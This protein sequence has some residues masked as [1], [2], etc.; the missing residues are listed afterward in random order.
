MN[1]A[2][3]SI[4]S[5]TPIP[6]GT[7]NVVFKSDEDSGWEVCPVIGWATVVTSATADGAA[8]TDVQPAFLWG[9]MVWTESDL[10]EHAADFTGFG[11]RRPFDNLGDTAPSSKPAIVRRKGD[12]A[13]VTTL[14]RKPV[15]K[16]SEE[17]HS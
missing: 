5:I 15:G 2:P 6:D 9:D 8:H 16:A 7:W 1:I 10:R 14:G 17:I 12:L 13:S 11:I 3:G 4:A